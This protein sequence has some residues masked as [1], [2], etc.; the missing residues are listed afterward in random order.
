MIKE[1][2]LFEK[3]PKIKKDDYGILIFFTFVLVVHTLVRIFYTIDYLS[4]E[5]HYVLTMT[6]LYMFILIPY[7]ILVYIYS[8]KRNIMDCESFPRI[9]NIFFIICICIS[10]ICIPFYIDENVKNYSIIE[11]YCRPETFFSLE[12]PIFVVSAL[13]F[14]HYAVLFLISFIGLAKYVIKEI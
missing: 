11:W 4:F 9:I 1:L 2:Q 10:A 14:V 7:S 13:G 8:R 6:Y 3:N 12:Y 5:A